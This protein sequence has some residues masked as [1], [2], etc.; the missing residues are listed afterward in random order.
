VFLRVLHGALTIQFYYQGYSICDFC[1]LFADDFIFRCIRNVEESKLL[2]SDV[3]A[4]RM[5]ALD[6]GMDVS[7]DTITLV[8]LFVKLTILLLDIN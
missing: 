2:Q 4:V 7:A 8:P 3:D 5:W 1:L 6:N